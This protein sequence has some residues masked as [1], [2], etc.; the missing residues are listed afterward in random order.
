MTGIDK[1]LDDCARWTGM[2]PAAVLRRVLHLDNE[3]DFSASLFPGWPPDTLAL[4]DS[5]DYA[6]RIRNPG[7]HYVRRSTY[8]G[9]RREAWASA[10][11]LGE[12][13]QVFVSV[14][15]RASVWLQVILP[16]APEPYLHLPQ[17]ADLRG[18]GH[19]GVGDLR[20]TISKPGDV[21]TFTK[22][23]H[24]WLCQSSTT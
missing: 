18:M 17:A 10:S 24:A 23:F 1:Y 7:F 4:F 2:T 5:L 6:I 8:L 19:H 12:R 14:V 21:E 11:A 13:T 3:P 9:Y 20:F 22:V 15:G 16:L